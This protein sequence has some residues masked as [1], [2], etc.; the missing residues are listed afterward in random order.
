MELTKTDIHN[1]LIFL[2]RTTMQGTEVPVYNQLTSKLETMLNTPEDVPKE[3][4]EVK[5]VQEE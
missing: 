3:V 5:E 2:K 1:L 4:K